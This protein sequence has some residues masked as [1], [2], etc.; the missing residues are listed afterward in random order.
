MMR[1]AIVLVPVMVL[2]GCGEGDGTVAGSSSSTRK[3]AD[4]APRYTVSTTVLESPTHGPQL[5]LGGMA[6]SL[7]PQCSGPDVVGWDWDLV[8]NEE[9]L[10]G[11]TWGSYSVVGTWDGAWLSVTE[12]P[13]PPVDPVV[14][15]SDFSSPCDPPAGGWAVVDDAIATEDAQYA[16][17][18]HAEAEPD[19]AGA[20]VDQSINPASE[21]EQAEPAMNDPTK[22]ILNLRFTGDLEQHEREIRKIWGGALCVSKADHTRA[23]LDAIEKE[24]DEELKAVISA[25]DEVHGHVE[26]TVVVAPDD[27]QASLDRRYG[28]GV[29][30][31]KA[32]LQPVPQD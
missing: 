18:A 20:W 28:A 14:E 8:D 2:A 19:Y 26:V 5:C 30:L 22:L 31:V 12:P 24:L 16:A 25:I 27:L 21:Q 23:E 11:T 7:P 1:L 3:P 32:S 9:A 29:V 10:V 17:M 6:L 13:G 15:P 4:N